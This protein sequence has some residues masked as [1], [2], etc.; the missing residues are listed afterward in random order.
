M[1]SALIY[2]P[3]LAILLLITTLTNTLIAQNPP[4]PVRCISYDVSTIVKYGIPATMS[5]DSLSAFEL[6]GIRPYVEDS[7]VLYTYF[8]SG[9]STQTIIYPHGHNNVDAWAVPI[10]KS[11]TIDN[12]V[13]LYDIDN[14]LVFS[15]EMG[16]S[17]SL[18]PIPN[19]QIPNLGYYSPITVPSNNDIFM[20]VSEGYSYFTDNNKHVFI[21]DSTQFILDPVN[22][23]SEIRILEDG[24]VVLTNFE[25]L[26]Q[27]DD[28]KYLPSY[29]ITKSYLQNPTGDNRI[30]KYEKKVFSNYNFSCEIEPQQSQTHSSLYQSTTKNQ[31]LS[32]FH[33]T[34]E[35]N[36]KIS[37]LN[38]GMF[39]NPAGNL[40]NF[41][42]PYPLDE[43][44]EIYSES[45]NLLSK[46]KLDSTQSVIDITHLSNGQYIVRITTNHEVFVKKLIIQK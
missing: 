45:G 31:N 16:L 30:M 29:R 20:M 4:T 19:N 1:K 38:I 22:Q 21:S 7:K 11:E 40:I 43:D 8:Q 9:K 26:I 2:P 41:V 39:P 25:Q 10:Y 34:P 6:S 46:H 33:Y 28:Q 37:T 24:K 23:N 12:V 35:A 44:I 13:N 32:V 17:Y 36:P 15:D 14:N 27:T 3:P 18:P 5:P 42:M